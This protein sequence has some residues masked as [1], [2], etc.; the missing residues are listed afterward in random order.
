MFSLR[1]LSP[2]HLIQN[3]LVLKLGLH[4]KEIGFLHNT[5]KSVYSAVIEPIRRKLIHFL[6]LA[7][8]CC[9]EAAKGLKL[10]SIY[11]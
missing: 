11:P 5:I 10:V 4:S 9:R 3:G 7:T 1:G 8:P 6:W 2:F